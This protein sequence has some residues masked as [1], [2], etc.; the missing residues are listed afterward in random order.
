MPNEKRSNLWKALD[1]AGYNVG[2]YD[3]FDR[4]MNNAADRE[5]FFKAVD[6]AGFNIGSRDDFE[7]KIAPSKYHLRINGKDTPVSERQYRDFNARHQQKPATVSQQSRQPKQSTTAQAAYN[8]GQNNW[9]G[10]T[11]THDPVVPDALAEPIDYTRPDAFAQAYERERRKDQEWAAKPVKD[12]E[13]EEQRRNQPVVQTGTPAD[14]SVM[15]TQGQLEDDI[16]ESLSG[17][18]SQV[19]QFTQGVLKQKGEEMAADL[20]SRLGAETPIPGDEFGALFNAMSNVNK[21]KKYSDK[22]KS[23]AIYNLTKEW[24]GKE[25]TINRIA[26]E[27]DRLGVDRE[28]YAKYVADYLKSQVPNILHDEQL[29]AALPKSLG[30]D[31]ARGF[32]E[33][34]TGGLY[35]RAVM[36]RE[37]R[38]LYNEAEAVT[39]EGANP[40]YKRGTV[41]DIVRFGEGLMADALTFK[42]AGAVAN[43]TVRSL[44]AGY[45]AL[46]GTGLAVRMFGKA[47]P[48]VAEITSAYGGETAGKI[49]QF[50]GANSSKGQT[51]FRSVVPATLQSSITLGLYDNMRYNVDQMPDV[52]ADGMAQGKSFGEIAGEVIAGEGESFAGGAK[53]GAMFGFTAGSSRVLGSRI[54]I[55]GLE[56]TWGARVLHGAEK[57]AWKLGSFTVEAGIFA[58]PE[59]YN[60]W[61][62]GKDVNIIA[63]MGKGAGMAIM[64]KINGFAERTYDRAL[65][66]KEIADRRTRIQQAHDWLVGHL[67][68]EDSGLNA[69]GQNIRFTKE[70]KEQFLRSTTGRNLIEKIGELARPEITDYDPD[71][72]RQLTALDEFFED[73]T[74][75]WNVRAKV[76][77]GLGDAIPMSRPR[78]ERTE[79]VKAENGWVLRE[80]GKDNELLSEKTYK[81]ELDAET[82][83]N[84]MDA[85]QVSGD[86]RQYYND[87]F[88]LTEQEQ[89]DAFA[90]FA[91]QEGVQL[92]VN[93]A[94]FW[95]EIN[96]PKSE[97]SKRWREHVKASMR[98]KAEQSMQFM[99][100]WERNNAKPG[101]IRELLKKDP[102]KLSS[103]EVELLR[104]LR[105]DF[106]NYVYKPGELHIEQAELEGRQDAVDAI[107]KGNVD[108]AKLA[109]IQA[110][111]DAAVN[112]FMALEETDK[113]LFDDIYGR[114]TNPSAENTWEEILSYAESVYQKE[115]LAPVYEYMNAMSKYSS[116]KAMA[117]GEME[118][119]AYKEG[120]KRTFVGTVNGE[121]QR[122]NMV[123]ITDGKNTYTL[124]AGKVLADADGKVLGTEDGTGAMIAIDENGDLRPLSA[125]REYTISQGESIAEYRQRILTEKQEEVTAK[126]GVEEPVATERPAEETPAATER[127]AEEAPEAPEAEKPAEKA[128]TESQQ[129][130]QPAAETPATEQ[131][132]AIPTDENGV[133]QYH[134]VDEQTAIQDILN[135]PESKFIK[136]MN[137]PFAVSQRMIAALREQAN[138]LGTKELKKRY[139]KQN[140]TAEEIAD[141]TKW[142]NDPSYEP[143]TEMGQYLKALDDVN[144]QIQYYEHLNAT[145]TAQRARELA[146]ARAASEAEDQRRA[147]EPEEAKTP[148]QIA[149]EEQAAFEENRK[150]YQAGRVE[151]K[152]TFIYTADGEKIY[153]HYVLHDAGDV[154]ASHNSEN[155]E[156]TAG[157]PK[158]A[159]GSTMNDNDYKN[160]KHAQQTA[161]KM[162]A[163]YDGRALDELPVV[164][165]DGIV[166]SGNNRTISRQ[167]AARGGTDAK[168]LADLRERAEDLGFTEEQ[169]AGKDHPTVSF[170]PEGRMDYTTETYAK[171]NK[172][173]SKQKSETEQSV[174]YSKR[175]AENR[176][177]T[178]SICQEI[179]RFDTLN[180]FYGNAEAQSNVIKA[181]VENGIWTENELALYQDKDGGLTRKGEIE[182]ENLIR[183]VAFGEET[184]RILDNREMRAIN[185]TVLRAIPAIVSNGGL[186]EYSLQR[187]IETAIKTVYE[188]ITRKGYKN[189]SILDYFLQNESVQKAL[190]AT[191]ESGQPLYSPEDK[192]II[193]IMADLLS[194]AKGNFNAGSVKFLQD[195]LENYNN[196]ASQHVKSNNEQGIA[197]D[198]PEL[199]TPDKDQIIKHFIE[200]GRKESILTDELRRAIEVVAPEFFGK[201]K[202]TGADVKGPEGDGGEVRREEVDRKALEP[203]D[204]AERQ[205]ISDVEKKLADEI[206]EQ[207]QKVNEAKQKWDDALAKKS[208]GADIFGGDDATTENGS[209][210]TNSEMG[211]DASEENVRRSVKSFEDA[212]NAEKQKLDALKDP[213][214]RD[215]RVRAAL[216][217]H[218]NQ[219]KIEFGEGGE[220]GKK[221]QNPAGEAPKQEPAEETPEQKAAKAKEERN[222]KFQTAKK[223]Y[224]DDSDKDTFG[225][226]L[227]E[228]TDTEQIGEWKKEIEAEYDAADDATKA[229]LEEMYD[230]LEDREQSIADEEYAAREKQMLEDTPLTD[231]EIDSYDD[232][233]GAVKAA[234]RQWLEGVKN[235]LTKASYLEIYEHVRNN[236]SDGARDS[237]DGNAPH[238]DG[239][240]DDGARPGRSGGETG[241]L[242]QPVGEGAESKPS[243]EQDGTDR[244]SSTHGE[245]GNRPVAAG[246]PSAESNDIPKSRGRS[247]RGSAGSDGNHGERPEASDSGSRPDGGDTGGKSKPTVAEATAALDDVLKELLDGFGVGDESRIIRPPF[248]RD[249]KG[250]HYAL[251][252]NRPKRLS[253]AEKA[254]LMKKVA[255][256]SGTLV[257]SIFD[258]GVHKIQQVIKTLKDKLEKPLR[259]I[260][261]SDADLD[262]F[263]DSVLDV[264]WERDGEVHT[265]RQ[266]LTIADQADVRKALSRSLDEKRKLQKDAEKVEVKIGDEQNISETLP[267]LLP[268]QQNDVYKTEVQFFDPKH[269]DD[270]HGNGKGMLFTNGTGTGKTYT[271]L[272]IAKRFIKQ[273]KG[274]ILIVTPTQEKVTDWTEDAKNLGIKL[275]PLEKTKDKTATQVKGEGAVVT[276]FANF[277]QNK[278][279]MEDDF[280]LVIYDESHRLMES[281]DAKDTA[282][283]QAHYR[284]TNKDLASALDRLTSRHPLWLREEALLKEKAEYAGK[285]Y[286][287]LTDEEQTRL[288]DIE[289]ELEDIEKQKP[290][291]IAELTPRAK[292]AVGKTKTVFLSATPFNTR[293]NIEYAEG[294]L[295]SYGKVEGENLS[296][297]E[298]ASQRM[299]NKSKFFTDWFGAGSE[300]KNG[301]VKD[302]VTDED[303]VTRQEIAFAEHLMNDLGTMSGRVIDNG[304]DYSRDFPITNVRMSNEFNDALRH[305]TQ[306][307]EYSELAG[308]A[309]SVFGD[310]QTMSVLYE[311]MK[312]SAAK[313]RIQQ[314]LDMGRKVVIFHRRV[315]DNKGLAAPPFERVIHE[316]ESF[317]AQLFAAGDSRSVSKAQAIMNQVEL[318]KRE[319]AAL[320]QWEQTLDYRM[321]RAQLRSLFGDAHEW[322][323]DELSEYNHAVSEHFKIFDDGEIGS[324]S[325]E[326][327]YKA[328]YEVGKRCFDLDDVDVIDDYKPHREED[329]SDA[330]YKK[331]KAV[332]DKVAKQAKKGLEDAVKERIRNG[333]IEG[334]ELDESGKKVKHVG[335]FAG[336][337]SK[338][339][340]HED[341]VEFNKGEK[342]NIIVV[343]EASGKEGISLHDQDGKHPRVMINLALPQSP[344]SFIQAEGRI[345]RI[346]NKSNAI[347]EYPLLGID[348]EISLFAQY[349]NGRAGTTENL[350]LGE[351]ARGLKQSI[352]RG[353]LQRSGT[354]PLAS[355]GVGG[356]EFDARS[357]NRATGYDNAIKD[358]N[359]ERMAQSAMAGFAEDTTPEPLGYKMVEWAE[360]QEGESAL[361]PSAGMGSI[362][363]Y[364]PSNVRSLSIEP[365]QK[366]YTRLLLSTGAVERGSANAQGRRT[367][368]TNEPFEKL[369]GIN[370]YDT[371]LMNP[372]TGEDGQMALDHFVKALVHL[373]NSGRLIAILPDTQAVADFVQDTVDGNPSYFKTAEVYLPTVAF[374]GKP[375]KIVVIDKVERSEMRGKVPAAEAVD[376]R[377]A[378]TMEEFFGKLRDVKLPNR[379]FD[380][381]A[382]DMRHGENARTAIGANN[383]I[384][385][386][387]QSLSV[388]EKGVRFSI[389]QSV[390]D[391]QS[392]YSGWRNPKDGRKYYWMQ[393]TYLNYDEIRELSQDTLNSYQRFSDFLQ[394]SD[395][396]I[397]KIFSYASD[398]KR[399]DFVNGAKAYAKAVTKLIRDVSGRTDDQLKRAF[400]GEDLN[401]PYPVKRGA[402]FKTKDL[403]ALFEANNQGNEERQALFDKVMEVAEQ[404][405]METG[406]IDDPNTN[407]AGFYKYDNTLT[408][409]AAHW[410][411]KQ[412]YDMETGRVVTNDGKQRS[413]TLLHE[414]IHAVT[415]YADWCRDHNPGLLTPELRAA[416]EDMRELHRM[417]NTVRLNR[418]P[419]TY[420]LSNHK[421]FF[422]EMA[423]DA[424][425]DVM[426]HTQLWVVEKSNG[427]KRYIAGDALDP[428]TAADIGAKATSLYNEMDKALNKVLANY[429]KGAYEYFVKH[430]GG[431][432]R[433]NAYGVHYKMGADEDSSRFDFTKDVSLR[434]K[435]VDKDLREIKANEWNLP[436]DVRKVVAEKLE[437]YMDEKSGDIQDVDVTPYFGKEGKTTAKDVLT[438]ISENSTDADIRKLAS[439]LLNNLG[440]NGSVPVSFTNRTRGL[441]GQYFPGYHSIRINKVSLSG[442]DV[443]SAANNMEQTIVHEIAHA[444]TVR[445][446]ENSPEARKA[447]LQIYKDYEQL[448]EQYGINIGYA[449][450]NPKEFVAEF[451]GRKAFR[452]ALLELPANEGEKN[453]GQRILDFIKK[454]IFR[455]K[456][457]DTFFQRSDEAIKALL[458]KSNSQDWESVK[459]EDEYSDDVHYKV[460]ETAEREVKNVVVDSTRERLPQTKEEAIKQIPEGGKL[461]YNQDQD[462]QVRVG[463][464]SLR[465]SSLHDKDYV[466]KTYGKIDEVIENAVKIGEEPVA[467]DEINTTKSVG[468]YY[469]PV[470]VDGKQYSARLVIKELMNKGRVLDDLSLYNMS[471]HKRKTSSTNLNASGEDAGVPNENVL[472]GYK[473]KEII[474][475]SQEND[476]KLLGLD[477][478]YRTHYKTGDNGVENPN[479]I[480]R[481][482]RHAEKVA[483]GLGVENDVKIHDNV[484]DIAN[485]R[486][487]AD[488]EAGKPVMG[489][490]DEAD[491]SVH[492]YT[493]NISN[494]Y[495]AEAT[496]RHEHI[497]HKGMRGLM[498]EQGFRDYMHSLWYGEDAALHDYVSQH[499]A[500]NKFDLYDT[501]E[502][503]LS[504]AAEKKNLPLDVWFKVRNAMTNV[505]EKAGFS[506]EPSI[507]DV[508]Y[509]VWLSKNRIQGGDPLSEARRNAMRWRLEQERSSMFTND[510]GTSYLSTGKSGKQQGGDGV[511]YATGTAPSTPRGLQAKAQYHRELARTNYVWTEAYVDYAV[512]LKKAMEAIAGTDV[513]NIKDNENA[514]LAENQMSSVV[515][516]REFQFN[517]DHWEPLNKAVNEMLPDFSSDPKVA[518]EKLEEYMRT[519]HGLERN[520]EFFVRDW[521]VQKRAEEKAAAANNATTTG[522]TA[523][524]IEQRWDDLKTDAQ[525]RLRSGA[526]N[527]KEYLGELTD[528]IISEIDSDFNPD[529]Q[530]RSGLIQYMPK[531]KGEI[532]DEGLSD[533]VMSVES[534]LGRKAD[535]FWEKV[536]AVTKYGVNADYE[537]GIISKENKE[538][539][540]KMFAWY[541]PLRGF[542]EEVANEVYDY[543]GIPSVNPVSSKTIVKAKGRGSESESPLAVMAQMSVGAISRG[544][545]NEAKQRLLRFVRNHTNPKDK[546]NL[547]SESSVW[548]EKVVVGG[549][550]TWEE[551]YPQIKD[552]ATPDEVAQAVEDFNNDMKTKA[553]AGEARRLVSGL[554]IPYKSLSPKE[555]AQHIIE[556]NVN[557]EKHL[558][559]VNGNPRAAQAMNGLMNPE[560][561]S[562]TIDKVNRFMSSAFTT[563][564]PSFVA[565][566]TIRDAIMSRNVLATKENAKYVGQYVK[567]WH[568]YMWGKGFVTGTLWRKYHNGTLDMSKEDERYFK[569][570]MENGGETGFVAEKNVEKWKNEILESAEHAMGTL[571]RAG[572]KVSSAARAG[573]ERV[574]GTKATEALAKYVMKNPFKF[575]EDF[576]ERAENMARF[577]TYMTS[578][579]MGRGVVRSIQDAKDVSVNFNRKG[580]GA[581]AVGN[582]EQWSKNW[583]IGKSAQWGRGAYLFFNAGCQSLALLG[584]NIK[585][586]P[587]K[588]ATFQLGQFFLLG[589]AQNTVNQML[590]ALY[591]DDDTADNAYANLPEWTRRNNICIFAGHNNF[592]KIPL[593]IELRAFYGLGDVAAGFLDDA[594]LKSTNGLYMDMMSQVSQLFPVDYM[595]E[596]GSPVVAFMPDLVKPIWHI[597]DNRDWTGKPIQR[598]DTQWNKFDPGYTK[599]F[600]SENQFAVNLSKNVNALTGGD[601]VSQGWLERAPKP[602]STIALPITN[603]A[604]GMELIEGYSGGMGKTFIEAGGIIGNIMKADWENFNTRNIPIAKAL[605]Q[606][607]DENT[608]FYRTRAQYF[609]YG[610]DFEQLEHDLSGYKKGMADPLHA[611]KLIQLSQSKKAQQMAVYKEF[612]KKLKAVRKAKNSGGATSEMVKMLNLQENELMEMC[613]KTMKEME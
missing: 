466:Y 606:Q 168:Y 476:R 547:I 297:E 65:T 459:E 179:N 146:E 225:R 380:P 414:L 301:K 60:K 482:H 360:M 538:H 249:G 349:F 300:I 178:I 586:H 29:K 85:R 320:L 147:Q 5:S 19:Q 460:K 389:P 613:V 69:K 333:E 372:P 537:S 15:K 58:G 157:V 313:E 176:K 540:D 66:K 331:R 553:A 52:I 545:R 194:K 424:V 260:G 417:A 38:D 491:G 542:S 17:H 240:V 10:Q 601:D 378:N 410:N 125:S 91:T 103:Y 109:E 502:E 510:D 235:D 348:N 32:M 396:E 218:R 43:V 435:G 33:S 549:K 465:H 204:D 431:E 223:N 509:M 480:A 82:E 489:W 533:E 572:E 310:Y 584:R 18:Q 274:R 28:A 139:E 430:H 113:E 128:A 332:F 163:D 444:V 197:F 283:V 129:T 602:I 467:A 132:G 4:R 565:S 413:V 395:E 174:V 468:I 428:D 390:Y 303:A 92:G 88:L 281:K 523:D 107:N 425:R 120:A 119:W 298:Y 365:D 184:I 379:T 267:F 101:T 183:G 230:L 386:N 160:N 307:A 374:S 546:N 356:K 48:T 442:K 439:Y 556:V 497:G 569:E 371:I 366:R 296:P 441:R 130:E 148:S 483:K 191:D 261:Y 202:P 452:E 182:F 81:D 387:R 96:D 304:Y 518:L 3:E 253:A 384:F 100:E 334:S 221:P 87:S 496:I 133:K 40:Y 54:G 609:K 337:D 209:M 550:V 485:P 243:G 9:G 180:D 376:L 340:K 605:F 401:N 269:Q 326:D 316:A 589:L 153:G 415:V 521:L 412:V 347:F 56:R 234:A 341:V 462:T 408:F 596:G 593:P 367:L 30:D 581:K 7:G 400:K 421:E 600:S 448:R 49:L 63:E 309:R 117:A 357:V 375:Y 551:R 525:S 287:Q 245:G 406:V 541:V 473:V 16:A 582:A 115:R 450:K 84:N 231:A 51:F 548:L 20:Q 594:R 23:E 590:Q 158:R 505:M 13:A 351:M 39:A 185:Q 529:K 324:V 445:A 265:V 302:R 104:K 2:S 607:A 50:L 528:F 475:N 432:M 461:C 62:E 256:A 251:G 181:L 457:T 233:S 134:L 318:F 144:K 136:G 407:T 574:I 317:A 577:A 555:K 21:D 142:E 543:I 373:N 201:T 110:R 57:A 464:K 370:K 27:A 76:M 573:S 315:S 516:Q 338:N 264:N 385:G 402:K 189:G 534:K 393:G 520:R 203:R 394:L 501:I 342:M 426:Q 31:I 527:Y 512:G 604:Y 59:M 299:R 388:Y 55:T 161:M 214:E 381:T 169:L 345:Y 323:P 409:N 470:N 273:G 517:R 397:E 206:A 290:K 195:F 196:Q 455:M 532:D 198:E 282:A 438:H 404:L 554:R 244:P 321:P 1:N 531:G 515:Q 359:D 271:G 73:K 382:A 11:Q 108:D 224:L 504:E 222:K 137:D 22:E 383:P 598:Q 478:N 346:G 86:A 6:N 440:N 220:K 177:A 12:F 481:V 526:I 156:Q 449:A 258:A 89:G 173:K 187:N 268:E 236:E 557:G 237:A 511:H 252:G 506:Y 354:I 266:W 352:T 443:V 216:E 336:E 143:Q 588:T 486:V 288:S 559:I 416:V 229:K 579:Q 122:D 429:N 47:A 362:S 213:K 403:R 562:Q 276:T 453:I 14:Y 294:Y 499:L 595:G 498:G 257:R 241:Q 149:A 490:F 536:N 172:V 451:M 479:I 8:I 112:G 124:V 70:E 398:K 98:A 500:E 544:V 591:G 131:Q 200:N 580:A 77:A 175:L 126:L 305:L 583:W 434:T 364:I 437:R 561:S 205:I 154:A 524:D 105:R 127:P 487:R 121:Q 208:E 26:A 116:F 259:K 558:L 458:D 463:R 35:K 377:S 484:S 45:N 339:A 141:I 560:S 228:V 293:Q 322:T 42:G 427:E 358:Y 597:H 193:V 207:E 535:D 210:F 67:V 111:Y 503:F 552:D 262:R 343:Q 576:N 138:A 328:G 587:I 99:A 350:A 167:I 106:S 155:F 190:E 93:D 80:F 419:G 469:T 74:I 563:W 140:F 314:H 420:F 575:V 418:L 454:H 248:S 353:I 513:M 34:V 97:T 411:A 90:E 344:I 217:E 423:N 102:E 46:R 508:K 24:F 493:P 286:W 135:T 250:V 75:P 78:M 95:N 477:E 164:T 53:T 285:D 433:E 25:E 254:A 530:D 522:P 192:A 247:G 612:E 474:H 37:Q 270:E 36:S 488:I 292:E 492:L 519:K 436:E 494:K 592:I 599:A 238:V 165:E 405:G 330:H 79:V 186:Q 150:R 246:K 41:T 123:V 568:R 171:F 159:D 232:P 162:G 68:A 610:K 327:A 291:V 272:G 71:G 308:F 275:T 578:R 64:S 289:N 215:S 295:F 603:P 239:G 355:Q 306:S 118:V 278:A 564:N 472:S 277:R 114:M 566:N 211:Y 166:I 392:G 199:A 188:A 152:R 571:G 312:V 83:A 507:A 145:Y 263:I 422:S 335:L 361:E 329:E 368:A 514:Y 363:R 170:E 72:M 446:I 61:Q 319:N 151:G 539:V 44:T 369:N 608:A 567:N 495:D 471:M 279:L 242:D 456:E 219:T 447:I 94:T 280:D 611:S 212:Y 284:I 311:T 226:E 585:N 391:K 570:F 399:A 255:V 227:N 325:E